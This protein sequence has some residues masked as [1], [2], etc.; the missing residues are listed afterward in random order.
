MPYA[1]DEQGGRTVDAIGD[2]AAEI[3]AHAILMGTTR[4]LRPKTLA[5]E[6]EAVRIAMEI[7]GGER[8]LVLKEQIMHFP[9]AVLRA[10]CLGRFS[11][12]LGMR[13]ASGTRVMAEYQADVILQ[14]LIKLLD[15]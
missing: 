13:M 11:R 12:Q 10:R 9:E 7:F 14:A 6:R 15:D 1:I 5:V 4:Q 8:R 3:F 2:A